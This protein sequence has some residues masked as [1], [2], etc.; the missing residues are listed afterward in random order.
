[1]INSLRKTLFNRRGRGMYDP[2]KLKILGVSYGK[3]PIIYLYD[4]SE[5]YSVIGSYDMTR[6][7]EE[8]HKEELNV[9]IIETLVT[10]YDLCVTDLYHLSSTEL[11]SLTL[12]NLNFTKESLDF[13]TSIF[14]EEC[15]LV[16]LY[17]IE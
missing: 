9:N 3:S 4:G 13:I 5:V 16:P 17:S 14:K 1:M 15:G 12:R 11:N 7:F 8:F 2:S 10:D 6:C